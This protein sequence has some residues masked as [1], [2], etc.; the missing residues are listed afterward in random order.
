MSAGESKDSGS[1]GEIS[2]GDGSDAESNEILTE[3]ELKLYDK[4]NDDK[5]GWDI[6][7]NYHNF[8]NKPSE[9]I[10][11]DPTEK[12]F[13]DKYNEDCD[14]E[15]LQNIF[16]L[17]EYYDF[18]TSLLL[19]LKRQDNNKDRKRPDKDRKRPEE[20]AEERDID[21]HIVQNENKIQKLKARAR[22]LRKERRKKKYVEA[23]LRVRFMRLHLR[24]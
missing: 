2:D 10:F 11:E 7:Q 1:S 4:V 13:I 23:A 21:Q 16:D 19:D 6:I 3:N 14:Q 24:F 22:K 15:K 17:L 5:N 18:D 8:L 12:S 9:K 20:R